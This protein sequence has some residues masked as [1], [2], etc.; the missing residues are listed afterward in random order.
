MSQEIILE[1]QGIG[2]HTEECQQIVSLCRDMLRLFILYSFLASAVHRSYNHF[3]SQL[4]GT[5]DRVI[6]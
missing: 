5:Q 6:Y 1:L 4:P 2:G 3:T